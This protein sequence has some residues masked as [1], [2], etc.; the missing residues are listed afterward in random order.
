[1]GKIEYLTDNISD[2]RTD[3]IRFFTEMIRLERLLGNDLIAATYGLR[4]IRWL[5]H[6]RFQHLNFIK[7]TLA[8]HGFV[9]EVEAAAAMYGNPATAQ[10]TSRVFLDDQ[11][12][13]H[14]TKPD[15]EPEI[16]DERRGKAKPRVSVIVSLYNAADKLSTF[17]RMLRQQS[18]IRSGEAEVVFV[19]GGSPA[20]EYRVFQ[21]LWDE[22]PLPAVYVRAKSRET[23]QASWNRGIKLAK[24]DYLAFLGV[25][26]GLRPDGLHILAGEL[27]QN[28]S[29]DWVMANSIVTAVDRK[30]IFDRDIMVYDRTGYRQDWAYLDCTFLSYVGGLYRRSI[31]DR[32][33]YYDETFRAAGDTEF[34]NRIL[35]HIR[36]KFVSKLLGVFNNYP[37]GQT[38][39]SPRA[40][41]EDLRAWYLHRTVAGVSYAFDQRPAEDAIALLKD[42]LGYR[43]CYTQHISTD[44]DLAESLSVYLAPRPDGAWQRANSLVGEVLDI[45]RGL[46]LLPNRRSDLANQAAFARDWMKVRRLRRKHQRQLDLDRLPA[47]GIFNDNRYEQHWWSWSN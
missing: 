41:I 3:R 10:A 11:W 43:K 12:N 38:T 44:L 42:T 16:L 25:D 30:G 31:H 33:G 37:D 18:M 20:E 5:G 45:Y 4:I 40:E 8:Q 17:V 27:D 29:I 14:R 34:K 15:L 24:G 1:M 13:R 28:P 6:D 9:R 46:E 7:H 32:C 36:S 47:Y 19:D 39:R 35:P 23:I 26:E 21:A 22:D 2:R